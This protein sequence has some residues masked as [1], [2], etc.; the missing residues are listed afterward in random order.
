ME[1]IIGLFR[2][3]GL[4][5]LLNFELSFDFI[6]NLLAYEHVYHRHRL[7]FSPLIPQIVYVLFVFISSGSN[8]FQH[9]VKHLFDLI[10][11]EESVHVVVVVQP[12]LLVGRQAP[13][14]YVR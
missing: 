14:V 3:D 9:K 7:D 11:T 4:T 12:Y 10:A 8:L 5:L 1:I 13:P 6:R 2:F